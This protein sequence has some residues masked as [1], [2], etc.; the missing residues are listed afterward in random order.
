[1]STTEPNLETLSGT[2]RSALIEFLT[3]SDAIIGNEGFDC[4]DYEEWRDCEIIARALRVAQ[5]LGFEGE[6]LEEL[7]CR[8]FGIAGVT[9]DQLGDWLSLLSLADVEKRIRVMAGGRN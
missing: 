6:R 9:E 2:Q 3:Q 4:Y 7:F 8:E 5:T 1:M